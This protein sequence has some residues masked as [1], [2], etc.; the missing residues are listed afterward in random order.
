MRDLDDKVLVTGSRKWPKAEYVWQILDDFN[1]N[2]VVQG[3]CPTGADLFARQ[4]AKKNQ[5]IL[6]TF[7]AEWDTYDKPAGMARNKEM[8][9]FVGDV[10]IL[11]FPM[12]GGR[13]TQHCVREARKLGYGVAEFAPEDFEGEED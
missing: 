1:P 6:I 10:P 8:L 13:G 2:V 3:G 11:A 12:P 9:A 4:W 5:R 7:F